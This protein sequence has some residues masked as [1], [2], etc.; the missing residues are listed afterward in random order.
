MRNQVYVIRVNVV[1]PENPRSVPLFLVPLWNFA[2]EAQICGGEKLQR[3]VL[4]RPIKVKTCA[5]TDR[6]KPCRS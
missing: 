3:G 2:A 6:V 1:V 5:T 4:S